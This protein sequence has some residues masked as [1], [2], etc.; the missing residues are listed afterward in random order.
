MSHFIDCAKSMANQLLKLF[1]TFRALRFKEQKT[2]IV[3]T[4]KHHLIA[5]FTCLGVF[6]IAGGCVLFP[7]T[8][9]IV[10]I[11]PEMRN[12]LEL[13]ENTSTGKELIKK[14]RRSTKG[15]PIFLTLGNTTKNDLVD[16]QGNTVIGMTRTYFKNIANQFVSNGV[17]VTSNQDILTR[18]DLIAL[19]IAFELENVIYA[20]KNPG[21]EFADDS[22][23]AWQTLENVAVELGLIS[24][25][26]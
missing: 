25:K 3:N 14:A 20:M 15:S 21:V 2:L 18:P 1:R 10:I 7:P 12:G 8:G 23:L 6:I 11:G 9:R 26:P 19:N 5:S 4:I 13:L 16:K 17:F 22:P 24:K